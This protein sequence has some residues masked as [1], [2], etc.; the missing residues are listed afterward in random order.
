LTIRSDDSFRQQHALEFTGIRISP[1]GFQ[2]MLSTRF[3]ADQ[4]HT[5]IFSKPEPS[6]IV[7]N[8]FTHKSKINAQP[9]YCFLPL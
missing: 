3:D 6:I 4:H 5:T 2:C 1:Q 8:L 9:L 7:A